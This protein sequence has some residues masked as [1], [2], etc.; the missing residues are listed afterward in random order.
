LSKIG[1]IGL[2][3]TF[4]LLTGF[5][6]A[7]DKIG[8]ACSESEGPGDT[9]IPPPTW[10]FVI[11]FDRG[12]ATGSGGSSYSIDKRTE[13]SITLK[14]IRPDGDV[15]T[16]DIDRYSGWTSLETRHSDQVI[17]TRYF[18]CKQADPLF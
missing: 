7:S 18:T 8:I 4:A 11:D 12:I 1:L 3:A 6:Y 16:I 2:T 17:K 5:G 9:D 15:T 10:S 14:G 13:D